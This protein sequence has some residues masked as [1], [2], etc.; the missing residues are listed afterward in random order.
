MWF[1][2]TKFDKDKNSS[3]PKTESVET[4]MT[5]SVDTPDVEEFDFHK[6]FIQW[7]SIKDRLICKK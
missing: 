6:A 3:K 2:Q 4:S 5:I 7:C 1:Q